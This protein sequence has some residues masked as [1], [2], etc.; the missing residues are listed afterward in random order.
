MG[1]ARRSAKGP[2]RSRRPVP[3]TAGRS[4]RVGGLQRRGVS[5]QI[6]LPGFFSLDSLATA[7]VS[8][9]PLHAVLTA[10]Y[11]AVGD[12]TTGAAV[13]ESGQLVRALRWLGLDAEL[14]ACC[15]R[16]FR[17]SDGTRVADA[18]VWKRPPVVRA[19]GT[20]DGHA[21][22]WVESCKRMIDVAVFRHRHVRRAEGGEDLTFGAPV[23]LSLRGGRAQLLNAAQAPGTFRGGFK[24]GWYLYPAWTP[25]YSDV[26]ARHARQVDRG[27][28][29]LAY[30][31]LDLLVAA[32]VYRDLADLARTYPH[33]GELL[34]GARRL[35]ELS[36]LSDGAVGA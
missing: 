25:R 10:L 34:S 19:D 23:M 26:L 32:G 3:A 13:V 1:R 31:T 4:A 33:L 27:G 7:P 24:V 9:T 5:E 12:R 2:R 6:L 17:F 35:P 15:A 36:E 8:V 18:G 16:V 11:Q 20:T 30:V 21:I 29:A 28:L 14:V 22:V